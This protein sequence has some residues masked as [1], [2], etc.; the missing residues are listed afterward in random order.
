MDPD[1]ADPH[2]TEREQTDESLRAEREKADQALGDEMLAVDEAADAV[3]TLARER[4]D[5]VLAKARSRTDA[6]MKEGMRGARA[7][8]VVERDNEDAA[9]EHERAEADEAIH[10]ERAAHVA[11]LSVERQETDH[12]LLSERARADRALATRDEFLGAASHDLRNMLGSMLGFAGLIQQG[13]AQAPWEKTEKYALRIQRAGARM[14]RLIGDL[15]DLVSIEAGR[16]GVVC[17][18]AD[19]TAVINEALE[20]FHHQA[21]AAGVSLEVHLPDALHVGWFDPARVLQVLVNLLSNALKFTPAKGRVQVSLRGEPEHLLFSVKDDGI[22]IPPGKLQSIFE[23]FTQ[24]QE[25]DRRGSG[26]GLYV[27][28]CIVQGHGG[29]LWVESKLDEGSTFFFTLPV[30][31]AAH[32]AD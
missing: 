29:R 26:L 11:L 9:L 3:I 6:K 14:N 2:Q 23:R 17:E 31:P 1:I 27:S 15:I 21:E 8:A 24:V 7:V 30:R 4:A 16:L 18:S 25:H 20:S 5:R 10:R 13:G 12:D 22:G 19:P 32:A 28:N